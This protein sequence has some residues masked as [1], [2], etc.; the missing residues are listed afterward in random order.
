MDIA[1]V[2]AADEDIL[3]FDIDGLTAFNINKNGV[4]DGVG[5]CG[6]GGGAELLFGGGG[7]GF[8][9]EEFEGEFA[10]FNG[11]GVRDDGAAGD[12]NAVKFNAVFRE[13]IGNG[14]IAAFFGEDG[15]EAGDA[16]HI[17]DDVVRFRFADG[18]F[19]AVDGDSFAGAGV[20]ELG[21]LVNAGAVAEEGDNARGEKEEGGDGKDIAKDEI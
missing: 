16:G 11:I 21:H 10:N 14:P 6:G 3:L 1:V 15:V 13:G 2:A 9:A 7:E 17:Q 12:G 4:S 18:G 5:G 8:L 19:P 20:D